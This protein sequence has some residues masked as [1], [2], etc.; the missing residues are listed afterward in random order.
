LPKKRRGKSD[1]K[2]K[3]LETKHNEQSTTISKPLHES[4]IHKA[5]RYTQYPRYIAYAIGIIFILLVYTGTSFPIL[6]PESSPMPYNWIV[7]YP[8][9]SPKEIDVTNYNS[10]ILIVNVTTPQ[11]FADGNAITVHAN[12]GEGGNLVKDVHDVWVGF[13][14][15]YWYPLSPNGFQPSPFGAVDLTSVGNDNKGE[16]WFAPGEFNTST[17]HL[18]GSDREVAFRS[19]GDYPL[20]IVITYTNGS[21]PTRY[22]YNDLT[23][24]VQSSM[25]IQQN[26]QSTVLLSLEAV[27]FFFAVLDLLPNVAP[28]ISKRLS[29]TNL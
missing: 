17:A 10:I 3:A 26:K 4:R 28:K 9:S 22:T 20:S 13:Y 21:S 11:V 1:L 16:I 23:I 29:E 25:S 19:E 5:L 8:P 24:H 14:G 27:T 6:N 2:P 15:A 18:V 7:T 12:A